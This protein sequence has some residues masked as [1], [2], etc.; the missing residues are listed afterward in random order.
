LKRFAGG[1]YKRVA[2]LSVRKE[3]CNVKPAYGLLRGLVNSQVYW[4]FFNTEQ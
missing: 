3:S 1:F 2:R 4:V